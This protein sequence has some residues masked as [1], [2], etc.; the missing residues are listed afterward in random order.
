MALGYSKS[1]TTDGQDGLPIQM[2]LKGSP[3][4]PRSTSSFVARPRELVGGM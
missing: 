4:R 2:C 3:A 1:G